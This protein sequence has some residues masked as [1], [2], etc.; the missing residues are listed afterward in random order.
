VSAAKE[1]IRHAVILAHP[2]RHSFNA[3]I[4]ATYCDTV[5]EQ[6]QEVVLR[7]LYRMRFNPVLKRQERP[8]TAKFR[9]SPDVAAEFDAVRGCHIFTFI[10]P[11]WFGMP[12]AMM[13]GYVD[14]VIGSGVTARQVEARTG[15]GLLSAAHLFCITTSGAEQAWLDEQGQIDALRKLS[16]RYLFHAFAMRSAQSMHI[17]GIVEGLPRASADAHLGDVGARARRIC[18]QLAS[19]HHGAA[20]PST[21]WDGS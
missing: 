5:R 4:A 14:R 17:G 21:I 6:G 13:K 2:D 10:Y 12:P 19:E 1:A 3:A 16:A 18:A 15:E 11:I 8:G 9:I 20:A 7:D